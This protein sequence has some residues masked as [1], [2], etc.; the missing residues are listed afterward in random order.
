MILSAVFQRFLDQSPITPTR[1][2]DAEV[3]VL[4]NLSTA[5]PAAR[6]TACCRTRRDGTE[7]PSL[8]PGVWPPVWSRSRREERRPMSD[9]HGEF[10]ALPCPTVPDVLIDLWA[11]A[12]QGHDCGRRLVLKGDCA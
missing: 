9:E 12:R 2:G 11:S 6:V 4:T 3:P 5:V 7:P 1:D 10:H 8:L